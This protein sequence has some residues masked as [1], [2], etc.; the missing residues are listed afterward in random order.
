MYHGLSQILNGLLKNTAYNP[1]PVLNNFFFPFDKNIPSS[2]LRS[3]HVHVVN[4][5]PGQEESRAG[6]VVM[7]KRTLRRIRQ[8]G[9]EKTPKGLIFSKNSNRCFF[10]VRQTQMLIVL[11][12]EN[13]NR[14][15]KTANM[16][17][18]KSSCLT[19]CSL[20]WLFI[21]NC[22]RKLGVGAGF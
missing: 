15:Y 12:P 4:K 22:Q 18:T 20:S 5:T 6:W 9:S 21:M 11:S 13:L 8:P 1:V 14:G 10:M 2:T 17:T 3:L 16:R 19:I 7:Q